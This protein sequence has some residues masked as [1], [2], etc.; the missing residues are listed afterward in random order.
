MFWVLC[1]F[2]HLKLRA[3]VKGIKMA[4]LSWITVK[5]SLDIG[6]RLTNVEIVDLLNTEQR[7]AEMSA[8]SLQGIVFS[9]LVFQDKE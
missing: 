1:L 3:K 4:A 7:G 5:K 8:Y 2:V 9:Q 6:V